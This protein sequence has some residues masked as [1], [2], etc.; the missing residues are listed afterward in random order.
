M[1]AG[2]SALNEK[3]HRRSHQFTPAEHSEM[4][5]APIVDL[6]CLPSGIRKKRLV[7]KMSLRKKSSV[8]ISSLH[9]VFVL[10]GIFL[11]FLGIWELTWDSGILPCHLG[12]FTF[13]KKKILSEILTSK[14]AKRERSNKWY[15]NSLSLTTFL[16]LLFIFLFT[17]L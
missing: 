11:K 9:A 12:I 6:T 2:K 10:L 5:P 8:K 4:F 3:A 13:V 14:Y 15:N 7:V 17:Y 16:S 1:S